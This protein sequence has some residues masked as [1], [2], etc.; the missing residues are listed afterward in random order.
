MSL[1]RT[2][3][4]AKLVIGI[5]SQ[6]KD[7]LDK[8]QRL[9]SKKYGIP[10]T[11]SEDFTF[12]DTDYYEHEMG[13]GLKRRLLSFNKLIKREEIIKI[14]I[15]CTKIEKMLS[16]KKNGVLRRTVNIDPGL[17]TPENF[18]LSTGKG[19]SHR[20][21]VGKGVWLEVTLIRTKTG[22]KELDWTYP[23]YR[24]DILKNK[25]EKIRKIYMKQT[26]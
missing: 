25:L 18:I 10:D 26:K 5:F 13:V 15:N 20:V 12:D 24:R 2:P 8:T 16:S 23:D 19:Y 21:F 22:Y 7:V 17:M 14:K 3:V 11:V 4:K 6:D 1:L 9:L